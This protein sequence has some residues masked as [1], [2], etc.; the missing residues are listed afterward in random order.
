LFIFNIFA[1]RTAQT[2]APENINLQVW[3]LCC[4]KTTSCEHG[5]AHSMQTMLCG[6]KFLSLWI[7]LLHTEHDWLDQMY[8]RQNSRNKA[9]KIL[10]LKQLLFSNIYKITKS[11]PK[12]GNDHAAYDIKAKLGLSST[13][14]YN[15]K[16]S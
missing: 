14:A 11:L 15:N 1:K 13:A 12:L 9:P 4:W 16:R 3:T 6:R 2:F 10:R 5:H 7:N 8:R